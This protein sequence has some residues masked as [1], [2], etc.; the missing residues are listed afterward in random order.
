M[1]KGLEEIKTLRTVNK[2]EFDNDKNIN[3]SLDI[4]E[5]ELKA[6]EIIKNKSV[7]VFLLKVC[8]NINE[9]NEHTSSVDELTQEEFVLLK[10]VLCDEQEK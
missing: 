4:I 5:K 3:K 1:S 6:L 2:R 10:E 7:M 8:K 9:Y